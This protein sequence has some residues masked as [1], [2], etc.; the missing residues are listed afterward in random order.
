MSSTLKVACVQHACG[1]DRGENLAVTAAMVREAAALG[2]GLVLLQELHASLYFCQT[3]D[4]AFFELAEA[5][6]GAWH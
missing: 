3:E 2:V 1:G 4:T 5:D 6:P